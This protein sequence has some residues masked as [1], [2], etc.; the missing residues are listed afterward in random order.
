MSSAIAIAIART[1]ATIPMI[2]YWRFRYAAA[3]SC[4]AAE[5]SCIRSLPGDRR[6]AS[7]GRLRHTRRRRLRTQA[8]GLRRSRSRNRSRVDQPPFVCHGPRK[9]GQLS[10]G[11]GRLRSDDRPPQGRTLQHARASSECVAMSGARWHPQAARTAAGAAAVL[12][13]RG[14][15][16]LG[17]ATDSGGAP[18]LAGIGE[19]KLGSA[20]R[21]GR[22]CS[23]SFLLENRQQSPH[24]F[25]RR[26]A[27]C[28]RSRMSSRV[29]LSPSRCPERLI[30]L[31][32]VW[33]ST[34]LDGDLAQL[35]LELR[36]Q[37]LLAGCSAPSGAR[38]GGRGGA[39]RLIACRAAGPR[40]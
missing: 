3:P 36:A 20:S 34:S 32:I 18:D 8:P 31:T 7:G 14:R 12:G 11:G 13:P 2:V 25:D 40:A 27:T 24:G 28:S 33:S 1:T 17:R 15:R 16:W 4:T 21:T 5:I 30:R 22:I 26:A 9:P 19:L 39:R 23:G 10:G 37:L 38:A 29:G 6:A 35:L